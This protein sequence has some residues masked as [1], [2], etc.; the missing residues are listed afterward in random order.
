MHTLKDNNS[1]N[2]YIENRLSF[3]QLT[4]GYYVR[5]LEE[6]YQVITNNDLEKIFI[7]IIYLVLNGNSSQNSE[8]IDRYG[9]YHLKKV[10]HIILNTFHMP[11]IADFGKK[12]LTASCNGDT[13]I[14]LNDLSREDNQS[15]LTSKLKI[16]YN[17]LLGEHYKNE[18][19]IKLWLNFFEM[20][21]TNMESSDENFINKGKINNYYIILTWLDLNLKIDLGNTF[22][23]LNENCLNNICNS[24]KLISFDEFKKYETE[25]DFINNNIYNVNKLSNVFNYN[26]LKI[27][28]VTQFI[29]I[30]ENQEEFEKIINSLDKIHQEIIFFKTWDYKNRPMG[31]LTNYL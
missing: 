3:L 23:R 5:L 2:N 31:N 26:Y 1:I 21:V 13:N 11:L 30:F 14:D 19:S 24:N 15:Y 8:M 28:T 22:K 12:Y 17:F 16:V 25:E 27:S 4:I 10:Y 18:R 6:N 9:R 20:K 29:E 7:D